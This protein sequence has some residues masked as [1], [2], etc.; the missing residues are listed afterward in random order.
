MKASNA[1]Q[2]VQPD[3]KRI[4]IHM[5]SIVN[6]VQN[7]T[8]EP[9][10]YGWTPAVCWRPLPAPLSIKSMQSSVSLQPTQRST[11]LF[12]QQIPQTTKRLCGDWP[13][14]GA[15]PLCPAAVCCTPWLNAPPA[16]TVVLL[17]CWKSAWSWHYKI[18]FC[19]VQAA[20]FIKRLRERRG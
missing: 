15:G 12:F 11:F 18:S 3:A 9:Q 1:S 16:Q 8:R 13:A 10:L 5:M 19:F 14:A 4:Y 20:V 2:W 7:W 6:V 17:A